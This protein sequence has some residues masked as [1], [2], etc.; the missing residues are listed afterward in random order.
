MIN[1]VMLENISSEDLK[2]IIQESI[3]TELLTLNT[4]KS[5]SLPTEQPISQDEAIKFLGKSR[6]TLVSWRKKGIITGY[7]L[8][9]RI[10]YKSS[11]LVSALKKIA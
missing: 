9:G 1:S 8:G 5:V 4:I 11:E 3:R 10:Y 2:I 6:Q 7:L